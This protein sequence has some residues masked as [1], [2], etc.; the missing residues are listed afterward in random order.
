MTLLR[1]ILIAIFFC[2]LNPLG[3][4]SQ[5]TRTDRANALFTRWESLGSPG[6]SVM[7]VSADSLLFRN[8]YGAANLEDNVPI[9]NSTVF[10]VASLSKQFTAF[11]IALL[12][13]QGVISLNDDVHKYIPELP[14]YGY[15]ISILHLLT[16]TSG[17]KDQYDLL[18]LAGWAPEDV[19][20]NTDALQLIFR[21]KELDFVPGSFFRYCNSGYSLLAL[22]IER[23]TGQR[24]AGWMQQHI[25]GPLGM[26]SS[27]FI[28]DHEKVIENR[29]DSY[30]KAAK[31]Y[32]KSFIHSTTQGANGLHTTT[33][34]LLKW[35][36]N[37]S[38]IKV[39][40]E[41]VMYLV[42]NLPD[43]NQLVSDTL[44]ESSTLTLGYGFGQAITEYRG[45]KLIWHDGAD[46]GY[47]S[48]IGRFPE[49]NLAIIICGNDELLDPKNIALRLADIF[50]DGEF[51]P[52]TSSTTAEQVKNIVPGTVERKI[53]G[54]YK[55]P[56][57]SLLYIY[58]IDHNIYGQFN[59]NE[60]K[61]FPIYP[62]S[63]N[64]FASEDKRLMFSLS[65]NEK[66]SAAILSFSRNGRHI[67]TEKKY[68]IDLQNYAQYVGTY[69]CRDLPVSYML[70]IEGDKIVLLQPRNHRIIIKPIER[71]HFGGE[72]WWARDIHFFREKNG[73]INGF[74]I[75]NGR[76]KGI[77]FNKLP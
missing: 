74:R 52:R 59:G 9:K 37:Y 64:S 24:F 33:D 45:R 73:T 50:M 13:D 17:M 16:H 19:I 26:T 29:A 54:Y 75:D 68:D 46:A 34:D 72:Y 57:D 61:S 7:V 4:F 67:S 39:G 23:A 25:F 63:G 38:D 70:K 56:G 1:S 76:A 47:R 22:V 44:K 66:D 42:Q 71:D 3:A 18:Y 69:L 28:T 20:T 62:T 65:N 49:K 41:R 48:Y 27:F 43:V 12:V 11:G 35:V 30:K 60:S 14:D 51:K 15:K 53:E 31:G 5:F 58:V 40:N 2:G 77:L 55:F 21:Q 32:A 36:K 6:L 8:N 10:N